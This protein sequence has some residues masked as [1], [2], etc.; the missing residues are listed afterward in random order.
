MDFFLF[1]CSFS[2]LQ[3]ITSALTS[4]WS[5]RGCGA[6]RLKNHRCE[7]GR[8]QEEV[9]GVLGR[10]NNLIPRRIWRPGTMQWPLGPRASKDSA[11]PVRR[12]VQG[13]QG[14]GAGESQERQ[15][16]RDP[17]RREAGRGADAGQPARSRRPEGRDVP[18]MKGPHQVDAAAGT[19]RELRIRTS[20]E[21]DD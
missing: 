9:G 18:W 6:R 11:W 19:A 1:N 13:R 4:R 17:W 2:E 3:N 5:G 20:R 14:R 8:Q 16:R 15:G 10:R 21:L 7:T 12:R